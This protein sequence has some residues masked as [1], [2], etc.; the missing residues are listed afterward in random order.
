MSKTNVFELDIL[1]FIFNSVPLPTF[2]SIY[3]S[4]HTEINQPGFSALEIVGTQTYN[5][6]NVPRKAMPRD[7]A[8]WEISATTPYYVSLVSDV[9]FA[10]VVGGFWRATAIAV[11]TEETGDGKVLYY[12]DSRYYPPFTTTVIFVGPKT[13]VTLDADTRF[14][15]REELGTL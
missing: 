6:I 14:Y 1:K 7:A 10:E 4:L 15:E 12:T 5:E 8:T 3:I 9:D 2:G 11:G 13:V